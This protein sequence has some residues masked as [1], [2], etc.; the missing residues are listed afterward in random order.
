MKYI[1]F[2]IENYRA[3]KEKITI[4][5]ASRIIPLVGVNEC[6]KT[7]ILQA[8][9][10]FDHVN[11]DEYKGQHLSNTQNLYDTVSEGDCIISATIECNQ[12]EI[13][14]CIQE[15]LLKKTKPLKSEQNNAED[16][17]I[18]FMQYF[19]E[20]PI[21]MTSLTIF[22]N[23]SDEKRY[24]CPLFDEIPAV[25][26]DLICKEIIRKMPYILYNDDFNDRPKSNISLSEETGSG[27][28]GIFER[29]F[30]ST[31]K[32]YTL[33]SIAEE[34]ERRRKSILADVERFLSTTLTEAWSKFSPDNNQISIGLQVNR[35]DKQLSIF[36]KDQHKGMS[37]RYFDVT[38]RSKGF[39]WY[40][41]FIMKI[42]FN[43]KQTG[44][45]SET[46]F[47][48]DEPGSYLHE[49]LQKALCE[50]IRDISRKEGIV[51]YC[52]HS[53]K[54]LLPSIIPTNSIYIV[55]KRKNNCIRIASVGIKNDT[56]SKRN[57]AMQPIYEALMLPEYETVAIDEKILCVE[58]IYD[59]YCIEAFCNL[60]ES[61]RIFPSAS[62]STLLNNISYFIAYHIAYFA[63]W[64]NDKE[65]RRVFGQAKNYFGPTE[66]EHFSLLPALTDSRNIKMEKM[67]ADEDYPIL[68]KALN[69]PDDA[70]YESLIHNLYFLDA[71]K[72]KTI[73]QKI[74]DKTK[75]NFSAL[76]KL[77]CSKLSIA[78]SNNSG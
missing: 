14:T 74:S 41:N 3:I 78:N 6:G 42:R 66:A 50:K 45:T 2:S 40:Y 49:T 15:A 48:L 29:V 71:K 67:I 33:K 61:V 38:D 9:F 5:L 13:V 28:H 59:K 75:S 34:D 47:L 23:I 60:P 56:I 63:L 54:L 73:L 62:A 70:K 35:E 39:I 26:N 77:I 19:I 69:L 76:Q 30:N 58:G 52:T 53:P 32:E 1:S 55:D 44:N 22:R 43:P 4:N 46:I 11:D 7:T 18:Q 65:G 31:K 17:G 27:W 37:S 21:K 64:D 72:R 10:C 24:S 12:E 36:I 8:I 57:T 51:V 25:D 16:S 20:T 68:R